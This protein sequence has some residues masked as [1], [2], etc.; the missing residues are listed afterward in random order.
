MTAAGGGGPLGALPLV[1]SACLLVAGCARQPGLEVDLP[2]ADGVVLQRRAPLPVRGSAAAGTRVEVALG[3]DTAAA[4]A[5]DD[6]RWQV[7][8][9]PR[10]AGGPYELHVAAGGERRVFRDVLVGDVWLCSGQSNMEWPVAW[11]RDAETEIA[12]A[13]D[14]AIRHFKVPRSW[15]AAPATT[16]AGGVWRPAERRWVG[17]F[18]AVGY[19][20][21]R[22]LRQHVD[23]PIG[24]IDSTWGGSRIEAWMSAPSLGL[25]E[26]ELRGVLARERERGRDI[27]QAIAARSGGLPERD[28]GLVDGRAV[29][30]EPGLDEAAW[31]DIEVPALWETAGWEGMD[32]VAWYRTGFELTAAE[33]AAGARLSLG[34]ID[35]SDTAWVNGRRIG[36]LE[37]AWNRPRLYDLPPGALTAG[38]NVVAV[39]VVDT[40]GGGGIYGDPVAVWVEA[41]GRRQPLAGRW[42]FRV[43]Q[44][45][46]NLADRKRELPA[47]L[48]N[49]MIHPLQP[50]PLAGVLWYQGES[51]A[52]PADAHHYR[53]L[54]PALIHDWRAGWGE[55]GMPFLFAQLASFMP[56]PSRPVESSWAVLR[57]SQAA[58]LALPATA[59]AVLIDAGDAADVH[60][61][62]KQTVGERLA[63]AARGVAYG[64]ELVHSGPVYRGHRV[65]GERVVI[66]FDH[67]AGGL[68]ARGGGAPRGFAVAG[69][70]RRFVWAEAAIE[71]ERVAVW[72]RSVPRPVAVRYAWA[73]NPA[74]ANLYNRAG[75]PAAPFRTDGWP[76]EPPPEPPPEPPD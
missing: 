65:R 45:T 58:A 34:T 48:Y 68:V 27:L 66:D 71:G 12:A 29:W 16:L 17:E 41:S 7:E 11:S 4:H 15:S 2:V 21:A 22:A 6:G 5:G 54:F 43:G 14:R 42:R 9:P 64:E 3:G 19:F 55:P 53:E 31:L 50:Y 24:L 73:D 74:G 67:A 61:R 69:E 30:A 44:A 75:L 8:L 1:L 40:G 51:N 70:D 52:G 35:D 72:S 63:L 47:V 18:T 25:G 20:F 32:G 10:E 46:V 33:A 39:R 13:G 59:Q 23:V 56:P 60:P 26:A 37:S 57:E 38:R 62:D 36:G 49:Q 28:P 76:V